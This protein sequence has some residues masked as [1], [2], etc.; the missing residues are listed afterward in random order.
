MS[1]N[2]DGRELTG[3]PGMSEETRSEVCRLARELGYWTKDQRNA[4]TY[5][6]I[7]PYP[8][9]RRR[10]VLLH[11]EQSV[12]LIGCCWPVCTI[13]SRSSAIPSSLCCFLRN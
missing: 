2:S 4:L 5:E 8:V 11:N 12:N 6:R 7:S 3:K 10:F 9:V 13:V 1:N